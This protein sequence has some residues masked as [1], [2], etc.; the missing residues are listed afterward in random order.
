MPFIQ[1]QIYDLQT[2]KILQSLQ[3]HSA[4]EGPSTTTSCLNLADSPAN[5]MVTAS[6]DTK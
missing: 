3:P 2:G 6:A 1:V 5:E 4:G